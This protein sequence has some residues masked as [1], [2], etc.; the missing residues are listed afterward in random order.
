[1]RLKILQVVH[2]FPPKRKAGTEI[3]TYY[4]SKELA[5][6]HQVHVFYPTF[7]N[8][9]KITI[10]SVV[11]E[12]LILHELK[13]PSNKVRRFLRSLILKNTYTDKEIEQQFR[14]LIN[15]LKP[16]VIHFQHLINLSA[17]LIDVVKEFGIPAVVTLNDYWFICPN[18]LLLRWDSKI[19]KSYDPRKCKKCWARET[20]TEL[21]EALEVYLHIPEKLA[22][23]HLEAL[24]NLLNSEKK[25]KIR[26]KYL[27]SLLFKVDKIIAPSNFVR[28]VFIEY[29]VPKDKIIVSENG[30]D[31]EIFKRLQKR[32]STNT[33]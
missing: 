14:R 12:N 9:K 29:G 8:I 17:T 7:E 13:I 21:S 18:I 16:H 2:G 22:R 31:L 26:N 24:L 20:S 32:I 6:R 23:K 3:Y 5:K 15:E 11:R 28:N 4:L 1:M 33:R 19:C 27:R 10:N 30:Y 25:F